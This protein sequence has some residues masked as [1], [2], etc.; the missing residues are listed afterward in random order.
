METDHR[1]ANNR[2]KEIIKEGDENGDG[3]GGAVRLPHLTR[4][5]DLV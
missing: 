2:V 1:Y 3:G 5:H 4:C